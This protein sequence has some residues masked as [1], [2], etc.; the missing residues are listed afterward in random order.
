MTPVLVGLLG[1]AV[2]QAWSA[3]ASAGLAFRAA[4]GAGIPGYFL[5]QSKSCGRPGCT[6]Y[7]EFRLPDG[8]GARTSVTI[9]DTLTGGLQTSTSVAA[10]D[11]GDNDTSNG[12]SGVV[13]PARHR[14]RYEI[15]HGLQP[16]GSWQADPRET[17]DVR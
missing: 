14:M 3:A 10:T 13:Y 17:G 1:L 9:A 6:W 5:R 2:W 4:D 8:R 16:P 11:V 12:G 7:G 15:K